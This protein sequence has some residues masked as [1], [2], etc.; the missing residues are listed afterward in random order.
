M[1]AIA[2][3]TLHISRSPTSA[4]PVLWQVFVASRIILQNFIVSGRSNY[5]AE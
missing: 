3:D 5:V 1:S 2:I 4:P